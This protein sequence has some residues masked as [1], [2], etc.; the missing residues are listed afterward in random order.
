MDIHRRR[1]T[2]TSYGHWW[3]LLG[4][5][6]LDDGSTNCRTVWARVRLSSR[7]V[8]KDVMKYSVM[9]YNT[10]NRAEECISSS[11]FDS[12]PIRINIIHH[13]QRFKISYH[14]P[15]NTMIATTVTITLSKIRYQTRSPSFKFQSTRPTQRVHQAQLQHHQSSIPRRHQ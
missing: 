7:M 2:Y 12:D 1:S 14:P 8:S 11:K 5:R 9:M 4:C 13:I 3:S 15:N 10:F 6:G